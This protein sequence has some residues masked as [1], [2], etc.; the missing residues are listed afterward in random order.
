M[1]ARTLGAAIA[2][3][4]MLAACAPY[5]TSPPEPVVPTPNTASYSELGIVRSITLI[6]NEVRRDAL[7]GPAPAVTARI[8]R[9]EVLTDR[10][11]LRSFDYS[12]LYGVQVGQRVRIHAGKL[13]RS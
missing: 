3:P 6:G 8:Y 7:A 13:Y 10:G 5:T 1:K 11:D 4:L 9:I 12:D 2:V